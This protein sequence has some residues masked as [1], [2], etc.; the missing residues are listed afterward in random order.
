MLKTSRFFRLAV[1]AAVATIPLSAGCNSQPT[2]TP[3]VTVS[4][5]ADAAH[6]LELLGYGFDKEST[7]VGQDFTTYKTEDGADGYSVE[8]MSWTGDSKVMGFTMSCRTDVAGFNSN[9]V[10]QGLWN[11]LESDFLELVDAGNDYQRAMDNMK[12]AEGD[13]VPRYEGRATTAD[14][15]QIEVIEYSGHYKNETKDIGVGMIMARH[16]ATEE[17]VPDNAI[18]EWNDLMEKGRKAREADSD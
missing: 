8:L 10:R 1:A 7:V 4:T 15:W 16:L 17:A 14:G 3:V 9:E 13:G 18:N 5:I 12:K 2:A 11:R 6:R